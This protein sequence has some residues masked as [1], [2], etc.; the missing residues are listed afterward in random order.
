[1]F[2]DSP[3]QGTLGSLQGEPCIIPGQNIGA[4]PGSSVS[5]LGYRDTAAGL[6]YIPAGVSPLIRGKPDSSCPAE[7]MGLPNISVIPCG[8]PSGIPE[9]MLLKECALKPAG[10]CRAYGNKDVFISAMLCS[11]AR[12]ALPRTNALCRL[13]S[14]CPTANIARKFVRES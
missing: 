5:G 7:V 8:V 2:A 1:M 3:G 4:L 13:P 12:G 10:F 6:K 11:A 14:I 9:L